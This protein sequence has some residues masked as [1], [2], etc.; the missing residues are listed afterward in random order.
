MNSIGASELLTA[1][2]NPDFE[3]AERAIY[4]VHALE[5]VTPCWN[6]YGSYHL[7]VALLRSAARASI[8]SSPACRRSVHALN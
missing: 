8:R 4:C 2:T 7:F 3:P 1:W 6:A 5:I